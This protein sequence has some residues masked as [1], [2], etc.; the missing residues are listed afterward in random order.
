[1]ISIYLK[2]KK[3]EVEN[4]KDDETLSTVL[5]KSCTKIL[6]ASKQKG[7]EKEKLLSELSQPLE[8]PKKTTATHYILSIS[9]HRFSFSFSLPRSFLFNYL[10]HLLFFSCN[11]TILDKNYQTISAFFL[12]KFPVGLLRKIVGF[13]WFAKDDNHESKDKDDSIENLQSYTSLV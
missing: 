7:K 6:G 2:K 1:M 8:T 13:L 3:K 5:P 9:S 4:L 11:H 10:Y 12:L